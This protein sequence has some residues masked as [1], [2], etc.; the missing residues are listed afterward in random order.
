MK[1]IGMLD[2]PYVRRVAIS[3]RAMG[4]PFEHQAVSVLSTVEQ[5]RQINPVIK[6]PTLICPD[7]TVLMDSTLILDHAESLIPPPLRQMPR[8]TMARLRALRLLGLALAGCEKAVQHV[9]ETRLRPPDKQHAPWLERVQGQMRAAFTELEQELAREPLQA[10]K[11]QAAITAAVVW[12]FV[13]SMAADVMPGESC[14]QL[15]ALSRASEA[16]PLFQAFPPTGP[17]VSPPSP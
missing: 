5:F 8:G 13:Q 7:G 1:L 14:P 12:Q 3:L 11:G 6:A 16:L 10:G 2:S 9:Y 4:I 17:G 15:H